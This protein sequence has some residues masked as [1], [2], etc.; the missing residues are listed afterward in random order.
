MG[1][2]ADPTRGCR[3]AIALAVAGLWALGLVALWDFTAANPRFWQVRQDPLWFVR[4]QALAIVPGLAV[5]AASRRL[6]GRALS[7]PNWLLGLALILL[8]LPLV[9]GLGIGYGGARRWVQAPGGVWHAGP[10]AV[11]LSLPFLARA[12]ATGR[13]RQGALGLAALTGL[14]LAQPDPPLAVLAAAV[15][16]GLVLASGL[17]A[18]A[19]ALGMLAAFGPVL[20]GAALWALLRPEAPGNLWLRFA[21]EGDPLGLGFQTRAALH[22]LRAGGLL[23]QGF[24]AYAE[25]DL[26]YP[27]AGT[28]D[29]F[30]LQVTAR[31]FGALGV[32][33]VAALYGVLVA[34]GLRLRRPLPD[35]GRRALALAALLTLAVPALLGIARVLNLAPF[36]PSYTLPFYAFVRPELLAAFG[37]LGVVLARR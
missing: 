29:R 22:D 3:P 15:A 9:P 10:W 33:G 25:P 17:P 23:G 37:A 30:L 14:S 24:G 18:R 16:A 4:Q 27:T 35:P 36:L 28:L 34:A 20:A 13:W 5:L 21:A 19:K 8:V 26:F 2:A 6:A 11:L 1:E 31:Q 7:R 12:A 32:G